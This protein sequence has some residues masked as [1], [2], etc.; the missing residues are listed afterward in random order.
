MKR[1][2]IKNNNA[3][4]WNWENNFNSINHV[5]YIIKKNYLKNIYAV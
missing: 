5:Y 4:I 1:K 3:K 2:K